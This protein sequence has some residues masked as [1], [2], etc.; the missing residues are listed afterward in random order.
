MSADW[1]T[2]V[3]QLETR[4]AEL[5]KSKITTAITTARVLQWL[6]NVKPLVKCNAVESGTTF[7]DYL[8]NEM[9]ILIQILKESLE[10]DK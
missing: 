8:F 1:L 6:K 5:E 4:I 10:A 9:E 7:D 3:R 2:C